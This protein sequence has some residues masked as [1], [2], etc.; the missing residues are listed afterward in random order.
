M[1]RIYLDMET[2]LKQSAAL[3]KFTA[4]TD[5]TDYVFTEFKKAM[6]GTK[7]EDDWMV[8]LDALPLMTSQ[9]S[10]DYMRYKGY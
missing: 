4:I 9:T 3:S 8:Y 1:I 5:Y 2:R 6:K 7:H 10:K